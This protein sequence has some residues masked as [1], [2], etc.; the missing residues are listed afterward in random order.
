M[1]GGAQFERRPLLADLAMAALARAVASAMPLARRA[2]TKALGSHRWNTGP[3]SR[4]SAKRVALWFELGVM[5]DVALRDHVDRLTA[6]GLRPAEVPPSWQLLAVLAAWHVREIEVDRP[7]IRIRAR[8]P[9]RHRFRARVYPKSRWL[10][11]WRADRGTTWSGDDLVDE[12]THSLMGAQRSAEG[13]RLVLETAE[14]SHVAFLEAVPAEELLALLLAMLVE[15]GIDHHVGER[16]LRQAEQSFRLGVREVH[17]ASVFRWLSTAT[18]RV[19]ERTAAAV[20]RSTALQLAIDGSVAIGT[21]GLDARLASAAAAVSLPAAHQIT[22]ALASRTA[23][24]FDSAAHDW[25]QGL[26]QSLVDGADRAGLAVE[27]IR[28]LRDRSVVGTRASSFDGDE[29]FTEV[30]EAS[31]RARKA[32]RDVRPLDLALGSEAVFSDL[33][34]RLSETEPWTGACPIPVWTMGEGVQSGARLI[35]WSEVSARVGVNSTTALQVGMPPRTAT[36]VVPRFRGGPDSAVEEGVVRAAR[37]A[38]DAWWVMAPSGGRVEIG[39]VSV[40]ACPAAGRSSVSG[41]N[42]DD[43]R[44]IDRDWI[45][46][47]DRVV[48]SADKLPADLRSRY[49]AGA[50]Y[51]RAALEPDVASSMAYS[52]LWLALETALSFPTNDTAPEPDG[53]ARPDRDSCGRR[54]TG[55]RVTRRAARLVLPGRCFSEST[56]GMARPVL[57]S[58][59]LRLYGLRNRAVHEGVWELPHNVVLLDILRRR[60]RGVLMAIFLAGA[61]RRLRS[62]EEILAWNEHVAPGSAL[63][64]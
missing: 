10:R 17:R 52:F 39:R 53:T 59:F 58:Q 35:A 15:L 47:F 14:P 23:D 33:Q 18:R 26:E 1:R 4:D 29:L 36:V 32:L 45:D 48:E 28:K 34:R 60:V 19:L 8:R 44:T 30:L 38:L 50:G 46:K 27:E 40:R 56:F 16:D 51:F 37:R 5:L 21:S 2:L 11:R 9:R 42:T 24:A 49:L 54:S 64:P 57:S 41:H 3:L 61:K 63:V 6:S 20:G 55:L 12:L 62:L 25:R 22:D 13:V 31:P 43:I 7:G